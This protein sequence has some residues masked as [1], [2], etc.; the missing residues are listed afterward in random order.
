M[1]AQQQSD[2]TTRVC[3]T[4][5]TRGIGLAIAESYL[6]SG[7]RVAVNYRSD[8]AETLEVIERLQLAYPGRVL[9]VRADVSSFAEVKA[10]FAQIKSTWSGL[11]VQVNNAGHAKDGFALMMSEASWRSVLDTD[12][13]GAF[14]CSRQAAWLMAADKR[15]VI[16][17]IASVSALTSPVGQANYAAAKA[18]VVAFTRTLAKELAAMNIRVN[19]VAPGFVETDMLDAL[20]Q[21]VREEYLRLIPQARFGRVEE[22]ANVVRFLASPEA[23]YI[24][25]HCLVADGGLSA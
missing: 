20:Q 11:D 9:P 16:V 10:M 6:R 23:S 17:N 3:V 12:L 13:S 22:I 14:Y 24:N 2:D 21:P 1:S 19:S 15:G 7:A 5:A 18:G 4:G 8:R 25:G